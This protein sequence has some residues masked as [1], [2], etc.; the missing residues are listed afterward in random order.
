M[1]KSN[2]SS[3]NSE[4]YM[5]IWGG[6]WLADY[7]GAFLT[8]GG[9]AVYHFH[10][11]PAELAPGHNGSPGTFAFFTAN[12]NLKIQQPLAQYFASQLINFKWL[13]PGAE[14]HQ[15]FAAT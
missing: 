7:I 10:Y 9:S 14:S 13:K 1:T 11:M 3:Q 8:G 15:L 6:L 4:A 5:D 12:K 2:L